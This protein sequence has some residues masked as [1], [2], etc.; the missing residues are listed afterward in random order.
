MSI[1][2][3]HALKDI[4]DN[5]DYIKLLLGKDD[6]CNVARNALRNATLSGLRITVSNDENVKRGSFT[7][8]NAYQ[9]LH[10]TNS[11]V[12]QTGCIITVA[13][14]ADTGTAINWRSTIKFLDT[15]EGDVWF[16]SSEGQWLKLETKEWREKAKEEKKKEKERKRGREERDPE[17][18]RIA[19]IN[20][21]HMRRQEE[22]RRNTGHQRHDY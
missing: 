19:L 15:L 6:K 10:G 1:S 7:Y 13:L 17:A 14:P 8:K 4:E 2:V 18:L 5:F 22:R 9:M 21:H 20:H 3:I 12:E 16:S 11:G